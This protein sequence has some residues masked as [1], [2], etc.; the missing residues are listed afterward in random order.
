M[1]LLTT[2]LSCVLSLFGCDTRPSTTSITR[3]VDS[4]TETLFSKT[5]LVDG[6]ATFECFASRS[7]DCHYRIYEESC[8]ATA[9]AATAAPA[10]DACRQQTLDAFALTVGKRRQVEGLPA[11]FHHCVTEKD[12]T[13]CG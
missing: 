7:G 3:V 2:L 5:T 10:A 9:S 1:R 6:V 8:D 12:A 4:G 11:G 13:R